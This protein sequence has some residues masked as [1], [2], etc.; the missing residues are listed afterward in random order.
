[1]GGMNEQFKATYFTEAAELLEEMEQCLLAL[2]AGTATDEAV[3]ALFRA[4]HSIKG[5]ALAF[6][7]TDIAGFTHAVETVL[8]RVRCTP[9]MMDASL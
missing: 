2:E 4:A 8:D 9:S 5:G 3:H 6:G 7:F 1:M